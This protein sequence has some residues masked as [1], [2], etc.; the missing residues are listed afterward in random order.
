MMSQKRL[1]ILPVLV[2]FTS[3]WICPLRAAAQVAQ[4]DNQNLY[5]LKAISWESSAKL[6]GVIGTGKG[7][8]KINSDGF[9]FMFTKGRTLTLL[10]SEVQT[11]FLTSRK[12]TIETY[13]NRKYH[14][15]G[16]KR[17][18]F[19]LDQ[20]VPPE[21]AA[22]LSVR[23]GR[24]SQNA[25]SDSASKG[26]VIPAH[27]RTIMGGTNGTLRFTDRGIDYVT[28]VRGDSRSWRWA[29]LQTLSD[30]DPY[31]LLLFGYRDTYSFDLKE[32]I[33]QALFYRAVDAI[34]A[35]NRPGHGQWPSV[36]SSNE[37]EK[38]HTGEGK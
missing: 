19:D 17:L 7:V 18:S 5:A 35:Q 23:V 29:D 16:M 11:F 6:H 27:H 22:D 1:Y 28:D 34:D 33:Q 14:L 21:L 37:V 8:L 12:L 36:Q 20:V 38:T 25:V 3:L 10:F 24:P 15:P 13:Q 32:P 30:L 26:T 4:G 9:E 31:H 2:T